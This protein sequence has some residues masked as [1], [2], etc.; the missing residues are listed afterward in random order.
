[1]VDK[2]GHKKGLAFFADS[3]CQ[4]IPQLDKSVFQTIEFS[5]SLWVDKFKRTKQH[6]ANLLLLQAA[7]FVSGQFRSLDMIAVDLELAFQKARTPDKTSVDCR[8]SKAACR[9]A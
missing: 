8:L 3:L 9:Y 6:I 4:S 5:N 7:A 2:K 1:M